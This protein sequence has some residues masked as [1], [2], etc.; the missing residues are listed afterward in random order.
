MAV[1]AKRYPSSFQLSSLPLNIISRWETN[2]ETTLN[3]TT[4][5]RPPLPPGPAKLP[6]IG[7]LHN[8]ALA[9]V[10]TA[11]GPL[12]HRALQSLASEYGPIM[13]LQLGQVS[14]VV[15]SSPEIAQEILKTHDLVF[16]QRPRLLAAEIGTW[17][18]Q[19]IAFSPLGDY[20]KQMK[21][22]ATTELL[23]PRKIRSLSAI[24]EAEVSK[25]VDSVRG[26]AGRPVN[27]SAKIYDLTNAIVC[28]SPFGSEGGD[29]EVIEV[30]KATAAVAGGFNLVDFYPWMESVPGADGLKSKI[31]KLRDYLDVI[32]DKTIMEHRQRIIGGGGGER[33]PDDCECDDGEEDLV[34]VLLRLQG[35]RD[36]QCPMTTTSIK[37][38]LTDVF[39]AGTDT[40]SVVIEWA[41]AEMVKNRRILNKVQIEIREAFQH[42]EATAT[43]TDTIEGLS[44]L[45]QVIKETLRLHTPIPLL[46][47]RESNE[48]CVINGYE[49]PAKTRVLVNAWAIA[50]DP[51]IWDDPQ[52]FIPERFDGSEIDFK[53][54]D[55]VFIPFGAGRRICPGIGFALAN[56][57]LP[58]VELLYHFDWE[59]PEG[60]T[61]DT[62]DMDEFFG[63]SVSKKN[64][65]YLIAKPYLP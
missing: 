2:S 63:L 14:A 51:T 47:P 37:A 53:G 64:K 46:L 35:S 15:V 24:R 55:F 22:I 44:Y 18:G 40:S 49:I 38:L 43:K 25:L 3:N 45:K 21:R 4:N 34:D 59:L 42:Q 10:T 41:M 65:L 17:G 16:A 48:R 26:S 28:K 5:K 50:R 57:E 13:H 29:S 7:N 32:L 33:R 20:W 6:F 9:A 62:L 54:T 1:P 61:T 8:L 12:P 39:T 23:G 56:I 31:Q 36:L 58:L 11:G 52:S 27:L 30:M 60:T 19:D